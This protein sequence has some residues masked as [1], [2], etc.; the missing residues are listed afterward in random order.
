[1]ADVDD[2]FAETGGSYVVYAPPLAGTTSFVDAVGG[3]RD[4]ETL[5]VAGRRGLER[6]R[7]EALSNVSAVIDCSPTESG[8][9]GSIASPADLTG[10]S[11]PV[12]EFLRSVEE[13]TLVVDSVTTLL[14]YADEAA[15]FRFLSVLTAHIRRQ[16][17]LGLFLMTPPAHEEQVVHTFAQV[18]DG[19]IDV[20]RDRLR[21]DAAET[22]DTPDGWYDR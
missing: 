8:G 22:D 19:R 5:L 15:V 18:F 9:T 21:I 11:M 12:S 13:P 4:G 16:D 3:T 1:V 17:G 6:L 20:E 2:W 7:R 10:V 14:Y